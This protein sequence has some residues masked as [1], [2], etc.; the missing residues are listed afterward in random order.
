MAACMA[1]LPPR[2][3]CA[4]F[5]LVLL[6]F[7]DYLKRSFKLTYLSKVNFSHLRLSTWKKKKE[8]KEKEEREGKG[9]Q[10]LYCSFRPHHTFQLTKPIT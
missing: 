8:K 10:F 3:R 7:R 4:A 9:I 1:A 6:L 2:T 5:I